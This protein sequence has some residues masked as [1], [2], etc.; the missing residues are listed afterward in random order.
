MSHEKLRMLRDNVLIEPVEEDDEGSSL[1]VLPKSDKKCTKGKV[2]SVGEGERSSSGDTIPMG[3]RVGD[4]VL[5]RE[6]AGT[7][8]DVSGKKLM[9]MKESDISGIFE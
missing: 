6:W 2:L 5:F 9:I 1:K 8:I 3:I 4:T 7:E